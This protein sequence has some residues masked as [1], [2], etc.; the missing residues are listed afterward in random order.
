MK[1]DG[2]FQFEIPFNYKRGNI[3]RELN[4]IGFDECKAELPGIDS[5]KLSKAYKRVINRNKLY[6]G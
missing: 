5:Y 3:K 4:M 2:K 6:C 1:D